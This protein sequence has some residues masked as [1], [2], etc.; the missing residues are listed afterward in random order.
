MHY[1]LD[2]LICNFIFGVVYFSI[3]ENLETSVNSISVDRN[4][5]LSDYPPG[6]LDEWGI[7]MTEL[8][9]IVLPWT[10]EGYGLIAKTTGRTI[11]ETKKIAEIIEEEFA[12]EEAEMEETE[13]AYTFT[14]IVKKYESIGTIG[15][16]E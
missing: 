15:L 9:E 13:E 3:N 8:I 16:K 11:A 14:F 7:L 12:R 10:D 5:N 6:L 2:V 1:P 4:S